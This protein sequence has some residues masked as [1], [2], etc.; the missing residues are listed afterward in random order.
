L[1]LI[2]R[3]MVLAAARDRLFNSAVSRNV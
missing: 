1:D 3:T 2:R